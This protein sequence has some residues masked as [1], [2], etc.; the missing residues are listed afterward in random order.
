MKGNV[1]SVFSTKG[2]VGKTFVC[3]NLAVSLA[4]EGKKVILVDL[5]LQAAQDMSRMIDVSAQYSIF[6]IS[7]IIDKI[8]EL[9]N[10]V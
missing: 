5:D 1:V 7:A 2:G 10:I 3:V 9:N 8:Q 6:D 4:Q